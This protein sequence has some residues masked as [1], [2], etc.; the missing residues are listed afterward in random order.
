M[1]QG[2]NRVNIFLIVIELFRIRKFDIDHVYS[3]HLILKFYYFVVNAIAF[4]FFCYW[5]IF[6]F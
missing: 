6:K 2:D 5:M 1:R 4:T 3:A